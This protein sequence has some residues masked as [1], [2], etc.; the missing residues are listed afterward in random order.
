MRTRATRAADDFGAADAPP[1]AGPD[2]HLVLTGLAPGRLCAYWT[3]PPRAW[4]AGADRTAAQPALALYRLDSGA[5]DPHGMLVFIEARDGLRRIEA[6]DGTFVAELGMLHPDG[7]WTRLAASEPTGVPAA[8]ESPGCEVRIL[9]VR[10]P[11]P[12]RPPSRPEGIDRF[13]SDFRRNRHRRPERFRIW[14]SDGT[15]FA[16]PEA[17]PAHT[18]DVAETRFPSGGGWP[19]HAAG[20]PEAARPTD[21]PASIQRSV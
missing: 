19:A 14:T 15:F 13:L 18:D 11:S 5:S 1:G 2:P 6:R 20:W 7:G 8:A 16:D 10:F 4:A 17:V 21:R 12:G 9:D 3:L